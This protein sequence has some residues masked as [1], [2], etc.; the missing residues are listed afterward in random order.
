MKKYIL[1]FLFIFLFSYFFLPKVF[2]DASTCSTGYINDNCCANLQTP[3]GYY[4]VEG[5]DWGYCYMQQPTNC[6]DWIPDSGE[7]FC[8]C[9]G[10]V[11]LNCTVPAI[12][13][14]DKRL[15][16][17]EN[18]ERPGVSIDCNGTSGSHRFCN[19]WLWYP[20][21]D[22][23][24]LAE[25]QMNSY[26]VY[27]TNVILNGNFSI[28]VN[29]NCPNDLPGKC[30][31]ECRLIDPD[32]NSIYLDTWDKN[33]LVTLP[34]VS[35]DKPGNYIVD[36][37]GVYTDFISNGG[38]GREDNTNIT[39]SCISSPDSEYPTY[40]NDNDDSGGSVAEETMVNSYVKWQ[41]N[42]GLGRSILKTNLTGSWQTYAS[43]SLSG[44]SDWCNKTINT[45]GFSGKICWNQWANDTSGNLNSTMTDNA[46]CFNIIQLPDNKPP[47]YF[48]DND[49][50]GGSVVEGKI[51]VVRTLWNDNKGLNSA[52]TMHN[53]SGV[54][55]ANSSSLSGTSQWLYYNINTLGYEGK[56]ICWYQNATDNS[57][58][59][60]DTMKDHVH[61][62]NVI[63]SAEATLQNNAGSAL[64]S[65][66][67]SISSSSAEFS[68]NIMNLAFELMGIVILVILLVIVVFQL[69]QSH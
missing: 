65:L 26:S 61:C 60:N 59:E 7:D 38:W 50:T 5:T 40:S 52:V 35:C 1:L 64:Q 68:I 58:N 4:C 42:N 57:G 69:V 34:N 20:E 18:C 13:G 36:Y 10:A 9:N 15:L 39:M 6:T 19:S 14:S 55:T 62:F 63:S 29:G 28:T 30:L 27:K 49:N 67:Q 17:D 25:P 32:G 44:D 45:T 48:N 2:A 8:C 12:L 31:V 43:C 11:A 54:W 23:C 47:T 53:E 33:G 3:T 22:K 16:G 56:K 24:V 21:T 37:C 46:H 41:D 51:V 66:T